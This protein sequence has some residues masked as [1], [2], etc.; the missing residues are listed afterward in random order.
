MRTGAEP[1]ALEVVQDLFVE[2]G[3]AVD[4]V[5][6]PQRRTVALGVLLHRISQPHAE[7]EC[8]VGEPETQRCT[9]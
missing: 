5:H 6:Q 4:P 1:I 2:V 8:L 7:P 9:N 3:A